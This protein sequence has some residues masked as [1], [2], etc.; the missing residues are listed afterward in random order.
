[1]ERY[2]LEK[3]RVVAQDEG[4]R[5]FHVLYQLCEGADDSLRRAL[6]LPN[7]GREEPILLTDL[8]DEVHCML[9]GHLDLRSV[10][11]LGATCRP[12]WLLQLQQPRMRSVRLVFRKLGVSPRAPLRDLTM[13]N[14]Q[15]RQLT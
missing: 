11:A 3:S 10:L 4:E 15:G 7:G 13:L 2:L 6:Q 1:M 8:F 12:L 9:M 14:A 5:S